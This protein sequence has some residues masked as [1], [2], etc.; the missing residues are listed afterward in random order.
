MKKIEIDFIDFWP[1]FHKTDNI[2]YN[3]LK[4]RYIVEISEKPQYIF[5]SLFGKKHLK[6]KNVVKILLVGENIA[7]DFNLYDYAIGFYDI[8][9]KDRYLRYNLLLDE[10]MVNLINDRKKEIHPKFCAFVYTKN[11]LNQIRKDIFFK[12][13]EYKKVDSAGRYLNNIGKTI[14]KEKIDKIKFQKQYKF[15]IACENQSYPE[16][17]T[18]KL[19]EAFAS[20]GIPIYWGDPKIC[21]IY[22]KEAFVNCNE[23]N[24]LEEVKNKVIELDNDDEKYLNMLG[25]PVFNQNYNFQHEKE[26]LYTFIENIFEQ[27]YNKAKRVNLEKGYYIYEHYKIYFLTA[28]MYDKFLKLKQIIKKFIK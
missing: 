27:D 22:N 1:G 9:F 28:Y 21:D 16:Y 11:K 4:E 25:K 18:E 10:N 6:Y 20:G 5:C 17:N 23:F 26:K 12:L 7:P 3:F 19:L 13:S 2:I 14:G 15:I 24:N 8:N